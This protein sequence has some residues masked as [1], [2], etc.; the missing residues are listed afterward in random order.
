V[1]PF[2]FFLFEETAPPQMER[3]LPTQR[4][5]VEGQDFATMSYSGSGTAEAT[6]QPVDVRIPPGDTPSGNTSGC[7]DSDFASVT[8]DNIALVQR[9]T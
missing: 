5:Y 2:D 1:Q 6:V 3:L 8:A 9:G 4:V 7:E